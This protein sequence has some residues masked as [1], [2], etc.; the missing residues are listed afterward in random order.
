MKTKRRIHIDGNTW[1]WW[2]G[3]GRWKE[4]THVTIC[5]PDEKYFKIDA[6]EVSESSMYVGVEGEFP[7][8]IT[9]YRVKDYILNKILN[10]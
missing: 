10:A 4:A 6:N 3:S 2:V 8:N 7:T 9:P 1:F 5:S